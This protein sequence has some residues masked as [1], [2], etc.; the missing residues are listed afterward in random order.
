MNGKR[1]ERKG[2]NAQSKGLL[3]ANKTNKMTIV[4]FNK[5]FVL[6]SVMIKYLVV[7]FF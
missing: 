3:F 2:K 5:Y 6:N 1:T 4:F 7:S